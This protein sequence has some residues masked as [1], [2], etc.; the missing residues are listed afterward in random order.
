MKSGHLNQEKGMISIRQRHLVSHF[1][2]L[3]S[4]KLI[5]RKADVPT[6]TFRNQINVS[7]GNIRDITFI[8]IETAAFIYACCHLSLKS[9]KEYDDLFVPILKR[10]GTHI[11]SKYVQFI[12]LWPNEAFV[13]I[14][15]DRRRFCDC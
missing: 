11:L 4:M 1:Q 10:N 9:N 5:Q 8:G 3:C 12:F 2:L 6:I 7:L 14:L 13:E 15:S